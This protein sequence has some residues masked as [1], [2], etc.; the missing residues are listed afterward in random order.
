MWPAVGIDAD[1]G[2]A[3]DVDVGCTEGDLG[4]GE[5]VVVSE[6]VVVAAA[7]EEDVVA[8]VVGVRAVV[9]VGALG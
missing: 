9:V 8:V 2:L 7:A 4:E 6:R 5:V 1:V 3:V